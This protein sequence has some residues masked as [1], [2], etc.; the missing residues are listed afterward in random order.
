VDQVIHNG[1]AYVVDGSV[2]FDTNAFDGKGEH[3][4][5]RLEP[6]SKGN[7]EKMEEGE[8][9]C[10]TLQKAL[11]M[12]LECLL[13]LLSLCVQVFC[14]WVLVVGQHPTLHFGKRQS[15][16]SL[17]GHLLGVLDVQGGI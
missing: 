11:D 14:Q 15:Q 12:R 17:R 2:Y 13:K 16:G 8:G 10:R 3:F 6:W 1:F 7:R 5:A 9:W 4:Y